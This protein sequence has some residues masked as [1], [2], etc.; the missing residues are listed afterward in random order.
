MMV[1]CQVERD[2]ARPGAGGSDRAGEGPRGMSAT[3]VR[4]SKRSRKKSARPHARPR[5]G[6]ASLAE[7]DKTGIF[8][9]SNVCSEYAD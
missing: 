6:H 2:A 3:R 4:V 8:R 5:I 9:A 1:A 7:H